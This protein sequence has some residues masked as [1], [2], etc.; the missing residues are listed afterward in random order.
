MAATAAKTI[1]DGATEGIRGAE[2]NRSTSS[3][4]KVG[5]LILILSLRRVKPIL[6][7][8]RDSRRRAYAL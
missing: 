3:P 1:P 5:K 7:T 6:Q 8:S 4:E 2:T